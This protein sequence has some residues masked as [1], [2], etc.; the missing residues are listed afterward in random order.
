MNAY[1]YAGCFMILTAAAMCVPVVIVGTR[2][3]RIHPSRADI[4]A[5][6][7]SALLDGYDDA[8]MAEACARETRAHLAPLSD[9]EVAARIRKQMD[10][11][12]AVRQLRA[13]VDSWG[14]A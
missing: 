3:R 10:E 1:Q 11:N 14:V 2:P 7:E 4:D 5:R 13:D 6:V 12:A 9:S 8:A